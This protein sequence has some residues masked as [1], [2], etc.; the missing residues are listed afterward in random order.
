MSF[1][2]S[3]LRCHQST[4]AAP[5]KF[6]GVGLHS[7]C[8]V[9][10]HILPAPENFG[11]VFKRIDVLGSQP[12]AARPEHII[13]TE[14]CTTIAP[15]GSPESSVATIEHLMAALWGLGI[16]NAYI[17]LD[18]CEV[19]IGD[20]SSAF[21]YDS[22][23]LVGTKLQKA[24]RKV[25]VVREPV[26]V[27]L[28]EASLTLSPYEGFAV[29]CVI[30]FSHLSP[31]IG[32][33]SFNLKDPR[34]HF[35]SIMDARTFC[36]LSDVEMMQKKGLARGGSLD[37]AV[38]VGDEGVLNH[39]G[40]RYPDEF[41]RH[42]LLDALGDLALLGG[43]LRGHIKLHKPGHSLL[44]RLTQKLAAH[45]E[46]YCDVLYGDLPEVTPKSFLLSRRAYS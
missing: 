26:R 39:E 41:V 5:V 8:L 21:F 22:L 14:L 15:C 30:D 7:G 12:V 45:S 3:E 31:T 13:S 23:L 4:V 29:E 28:G 20:G 34:K 33:Q 25:Y 27:E 44:A 42:K 17:E 10:C 38:V 40:L 46:E 16:D 35:L 24:P 11:V 2:L 9:N 18:H 43:D 6:T 36:R 19:P 32:R 37:N 1:G